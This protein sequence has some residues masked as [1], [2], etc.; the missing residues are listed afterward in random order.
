MTS[1]E[2]TLGEE[3]ETTEVTAEVAIGT[4]VFV[5]VVSLGDFADG[6]PGP[7]RL[8]IA[9][10]LVNARLGDEIVTALEPTY[11]TF[12]VRLRHVLDEDGNPTSEEVW[13]VE[14]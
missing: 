14:R 2:D 12:R 5:A 8:E 9:R 1:V 3:W 6:E 13:R 11:R 10:E 4:D 7:D